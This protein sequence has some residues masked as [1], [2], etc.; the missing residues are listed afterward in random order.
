MIPL[1]KARQIADLVVDQLRPF[2][3]RIEIAGSIRRMRSEVG[4]VD[5]VIETSNRRALLDRVA[6]R[7]KLEKNGEQYAVAVMKDGTQLDLWF[8][9]TPT[10]PS[11]NEM[12]AEPDKKPDNFGSILLA[13][14]GST[15]HNIALAERA[16]RLGLRWNPHWGIYQ[17]GVCIASKTEADIYAALGLPFIEPVHRQFTQR[18]EQQR[19]I[20]QEFWKE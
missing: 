14:T 10:P 2:A 1:I 7:C 11:Q 20:N 16:Q 3:T 12:F 9:Y 15:E 6:K 8:S 5:L 4:D 13:R 19:L 18:H 17:G